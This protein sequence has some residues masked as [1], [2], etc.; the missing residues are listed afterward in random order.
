MT[1][2]IIRI[3]DITED[4]LAP[5]WVGTTNNLTFRGVTPR[6]E[7]QTSVDPFTPATNRPQYIAS[8]TQANTAPVLD[9]DGNPIRGN[10]RRAVPRRRRAFAPPPGSGPSDPF[11]K[12]KPVPESPISDA[13][14][15]SGSTTTGGSKL[16]I[17][18][19]SV[20]S[21]TLSDEAAM[22][23]AP[24]IS[25]QPSTLTL[26]A[27]QKTTWT[28]V[29]M[30]LDGLTTDK[31]SFRYDPRSIDIEDVMFG[32]AMSIDPK[33][34]PVVSVDHANGIVRIQSSDGKPLA[35]RSGGE[36]F[37]LSL[38]GVLAGEAVLVLDPAEL[39]NGK[40]QVVMGA[41]SGGRARV[42]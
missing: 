11:A 27:G 18:S 30:D 12:P 41:I 16:T 22:R 37:M 8:A 25:P 7:S 32:P 31:L 14:S 19:T 3:P 10:R 35:F 6:I 38:Q 9:V 26:K 20:A 17:A 23:L 39:K 36:L 5:M 24:R 42:E 4:D 29:G 1:P 15:G 2:H 33:T 21:Q 40:G 13:T 34:P 28:I